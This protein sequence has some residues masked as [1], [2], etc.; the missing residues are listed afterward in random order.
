MAK[1]TGK[2]S[3][4]GRKRTPRDVVAAKPTRCRHCGSTERTAYHH[5][6][7][8]P[9]PCTGTY[10][11]E[12]VTRLVRR[13]TECKNCGRARIDTHGEYLPTDAIKT[14]EPQR[15]TV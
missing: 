10:D 7:H 15:H 13:R 9:A 4:T 3:T 8:H 5:T 12:P 2:R 11:G 1:R 6:T 14:G